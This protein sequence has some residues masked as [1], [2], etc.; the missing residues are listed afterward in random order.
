MKRRPVAVRAR[1]AGLGLDPRVSQAR[2]N[3]GRTRAVISVMMRTMRRFIRTGVYLGAWSSLLV[4][5]ACGKA[6][7]QADSAVE[8]AEAPAAL[9]GYDIR[10]LRPGKEDLEVVFDEQFARARSE[11]KQVAVLFSAGWCE[12]CR[13]LELELGNVQPQSAIGHVR[14]F[15]LNEEDW[16]GATRMNEFNALRRRWNPVLNS[17]PLFYVLDEQ[18]KGIEEMRDAIDRLKAQSLEPSVA[19]WFGSVRHGGLTAS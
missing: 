1:L 16:D 18:G 14:L 2:Y 15:E 17:Y 4:G 12:P 11:G 8:A 9:V 3:P 5:P 10:R 19:N 13:I 6:S 7:P